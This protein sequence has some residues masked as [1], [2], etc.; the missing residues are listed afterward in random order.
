MLLNV[1]IFT[2]HLCLQSEILVKCN[3]LEDMDHHKT[4]SRIN[5]LQCLEADVCIYIL[6]FLDDPADVVRASAVSCFWRQFSK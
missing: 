3:T 4:E 1:V 5:F 6:S 2:N